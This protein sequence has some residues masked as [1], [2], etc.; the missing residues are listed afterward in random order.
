MPDTFDNSK[1]KSQ[2]KSGI[3]YLPDQSMMTSEQ[4]IIRGCMNLLA[5]PDRNK[6][7][8]QKEDPTQTSV[9]EP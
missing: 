4:E 2:S 5:T 6:D 9:K 3:K 8:E 7:G 1:F